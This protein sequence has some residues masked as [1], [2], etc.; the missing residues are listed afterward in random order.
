MWSF[1]RIIKTNTTQE[2]V[3]KWEEL[4]VTEVHLTKKNIYLTVKSFIHSTCIIPYN[5][6]I[7]SKIIVKIVKLKK[8]ISL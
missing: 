8:N 3:R 6:I 1:F 4:Y 2:N 7:I 5:N